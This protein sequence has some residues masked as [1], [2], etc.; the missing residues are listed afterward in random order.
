MLVLEM[1]PLGIEKLE[2]QVAEIIFT[3]H[4]FWLFTQKQEN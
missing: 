4:P 1:G 3:F 2:V